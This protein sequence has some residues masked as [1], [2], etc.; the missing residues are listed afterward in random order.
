M[1]K[2]NTAVIIWRCCCL[3]ETSL[4]LL[5]CRNPSG[6]GTNR[7]WPNWSYNYSWLNQHWTQDCIFRHLMTHAILWL[8]VDEVGLV[9]VS[10]GFSA[11]QILTLYLLMSTSKL[12]WVSSKNPVTLDSLRTG[13]SGY[14]IPVRARFSVPVQIELGPQTAPCT[15]GAGFLPRG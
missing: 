1:N 14:R 13:R 8:Y 11:G 12:K 7:H 4:Y 2:S 5:K 10:L 3:V 9:S 15:M 6:K